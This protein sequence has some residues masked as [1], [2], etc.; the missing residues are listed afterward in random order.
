MA[1]RRTTAIW[2]GLSAAL[3]TSLG[4]A[5]GAAEAGRV[6]LR[7]RATP[8]GEVLTNGAG[9]VLLIFPREG[10]S[11]ALCRRIRSCLEDW[12]P[13]T[14]TGPPLAGRGVDANLIGTTP[15]RGRRLAVTYAGWPLHTYRFAY[16]ARNSVLNIGIRQFGDRWD[17]LGPAGQFVS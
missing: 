5:A 6:H 2:V 17:A 8:A 13:V 15:Y 1:G 3:L 14:T 9:Y 4:P 16:S 12:P 11:L 10:N 7:L